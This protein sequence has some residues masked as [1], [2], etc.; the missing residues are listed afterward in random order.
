MDFYG[1]RNKVLYAWNNVPWPHLPVHLLCTTAL[2]SIHTS[3][4][5]RLLTRLRGVL[6]AYGAIASRKT[7]RAAVSVESYRLS[8]ELK[9]RGTIPLEE[10][11]NRL[12]DT[13][14]LPAA[15]TNHC[16]VT[17]NG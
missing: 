15:G 17:T 13:R 9:R 2:T 10:I 6:A 7:S 5:R 3:N 12:P 16:V 4:P 14:T 8:R 11:K 1:A